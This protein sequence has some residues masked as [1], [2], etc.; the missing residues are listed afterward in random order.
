MKPSPFPLPA[1][2]LALVA[3]RFATLGD[4]VRL[5]VLQSLE[6]GEMTVSH[7]TARTG[8]SQSNISKHLKVMYDAGLVSRRQEGTSVYYGIADP[9]V[10]K[11]CDLVCSAAQ[12][13]ARVRIAE[14]NAI[15]RPRKGSRR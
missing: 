15:A 9:V 14:L 13:E 7:I 3:R 6:S 2:M 11:L 10:F 1:S 12:R 4:P 5:R 8:A